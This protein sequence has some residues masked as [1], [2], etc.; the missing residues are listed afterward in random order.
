M[1]KKCVRLQSKCANGRVDKMLK[2]LLNLCKQHKE[3]SLY[4][5]C[6]FFSFQ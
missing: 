4:Y 6:L 1:V 5:C 3:E 2:Q